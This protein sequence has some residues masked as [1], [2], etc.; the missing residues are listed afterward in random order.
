MSQKIN[1]L[2]VD[3]H[4]IMRKAV[5]SL[6]KFLPYVENVYEAENG[7][8]CIKHLSSTSVDVV[9]LD[10]SMPLMN[11][12]DCLRQIR[13][14]WPDVKVIIL[15]QFS[16]TKYYRTLMGL[17]ASG[18]LL[19][20]TT[21]PVFVDAFEQIVFKNIT[22]IS[23]EIETDLTVYDDDN[24]TKLLGPRESEVLTLICQGLAS[25]EVAKQLKISVHTVH[26]H[27]KAIL[28]KINCNST[29]ALV[30]WAIS[31]EMI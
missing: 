29:A 23:P 14:D 5:V 31:H 26:N 4:P 21:E 6:V 9:L 28:A 16:D 30:Q 7:F 24:Q 27:R 25:N 15:T 8:L 1:V 10:I 2:V 17:G 11:G 19:K 20:S 3:D 12:I 13:T 22:V 18:Y